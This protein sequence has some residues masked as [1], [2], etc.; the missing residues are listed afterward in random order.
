MSRCPTLLA[1]LIAAISLLAAGPALA[2]PITY[3]VDSGIGYS[4]LN[5]ASK[6]DHVG[7]I[8]GD[9]TMDYDASADTFT[10]LTSNVWLDSPDY[11]FDITGGVLHGD[12][13]GYLDFTMVGTGEY[14]Q[15]ASFT[16]IGGPPICC[17]VGGP[18][19]ATVPQF[20]LWGSSSGAN[21]IGATPV[22][23]TIVGNSASPMPE[24]SAALVFGVGLLFV[25]SAVRRRTR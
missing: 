25:Q 2:V 12:G 3:Q 13:A 9:I 7:S 19:Y 11:L 20:N 14:A 21:P 22:A 18:N 1:S 16:F 4:Q 6:V 8:Y 5:A 23:I 24:P 15:T 17:G 10:V